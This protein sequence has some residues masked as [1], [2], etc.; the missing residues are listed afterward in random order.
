MIRSRT[1][2]SSSPFW[3]L[4]I[5]HHLSLLP[6]PADDNN[7]H[8]GQDEPFYYDASGFAQGIDMLTDTGKGIYARKWGKGDCD[9]IGDGGLGF[10]DQWTVEKIEY[11][12]VD[13]P[14]E[15]KKGE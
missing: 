9:L 11:S 8:S 5:H 15:K 10:K 7:K 3:L 4:P 2:L 12:Y 1:L 14:V 6:T 13:V